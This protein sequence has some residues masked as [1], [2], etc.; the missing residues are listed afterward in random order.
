MVAFGFDE[1]YGTPGPRQVT[2][3]PSPMFHTTSAGS[4]V[5]VADTAPADAVADIERH[6]ADPTHNQ[7]LT[8]TS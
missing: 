2:V 6:D 1:S 7:E 5:A 8:S 3:W 4:A